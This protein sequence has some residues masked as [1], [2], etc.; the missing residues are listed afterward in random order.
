MAESREKLIDKIRKFAKDNEMLEHLARELQELP[1]QDEKA[2]KY[3]FVESDDS[4]YEDE[5]EG[6]DILSED[7][8]EGDDEEIDE[9]VDEEIGEEADQRSDGQPS[10]EN[11]ELIEELE[12]E[13]RQDQNGEIMEGANEELS[14]QSGNGLV[15]ENRQVAVA[16]R[17][18]ASLSNG[19]LDREVLEEVD[20]EY[21]SDDGYE[22]E[23][24]D[25]GRP[26]LRRTKT[27][28][29]RNIRQDKANQRD[30]YRHYTFLDEAYVHGF[31]DGEAVREKFYRNKPDHVFEIR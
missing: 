1:T 8:T 3:E 4:S 30:R 29:K 31:M 16:V 23:V 5:P 27:E 20:L 13:A 21:A 25:G 2:V 15:P 22:A 14:Q 10:T 28:T 12:D 7:S 18:E 26:P 19:E 17:D 11:G 24:N 6:G 9:E